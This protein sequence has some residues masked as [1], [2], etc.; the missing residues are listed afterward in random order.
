MSSDLQRLFTVEFAR[1]RDGLEAERVLRAGLAPFE[2]RLGSRPPPM[3]RDYRQLIEDRFVLKLSEAGCGVGFAMLL[4]QR[5]A[6]YI[7]AVAV[8]P[9]RQGCGGG[10]LLIASAA[11]LASQLCLPSLQLHT[12]AIA[13]PVGFYRAVGFN[14]VGDGHVNSRGFI[15]MEKSIETALDR[16]LRCA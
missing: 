4:P 16:L 9:A 5:D 1:P 10:R 3:D 12:P 15:R 13:G 7:D 11:K 6:L 2:T 8:A 14:V